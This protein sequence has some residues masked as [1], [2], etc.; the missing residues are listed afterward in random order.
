MRAPMRARSHAPRLATAR[1]AGR[2]QPACSAARAPPA[3]PCAARLLG[4]SY[5]E[6]RRKEPSSG[7]LLAILGYDIFVTERKAVDIAAQPC[8]RLPPLLPFPAPPAPPSGEAARL[9]S[10]ASAAPGERGALPSMLVVNYA[11]FT[12]SPSAA[13]LFSAEGECAADGEGGSLVQ[14]FAI[15]PH[16]GLSADDGGPPTPAARLLRRWLLTAEHDEVTP[17]RTQRRPSAACSAAREA[18]GPARPS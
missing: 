11:L 15:P 2:R 4:C 1:R 16:I 9:A 8:L 3:L 5:L 7:P 12:Y 17:T 10:A 6:S 14:Y 13:S 18:V